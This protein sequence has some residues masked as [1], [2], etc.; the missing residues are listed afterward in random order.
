MST[1]VNPVCS[2]IRVF[3]ILILK[4]HN[5]MPKKW[6]VLF[7]CIISFSAH[8]MGLFSKEFFISAG[9]EKNISIG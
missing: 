7:V 5:T 3:V 4:L 2:I 8:G 6:I 1:R 9:Y